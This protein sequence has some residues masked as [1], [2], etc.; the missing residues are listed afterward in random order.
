MN[1]KDWKNILILMPI[2]LFAFFSNIWVRPADLMEAR[3][4]IT[5]REMIQNANYVI[6]TLNG[7]LRFEKPPLPTWLTAFV[8]KVTGNI[9]DEWL[10]RIPVAL[11]A[12]L[13]IILLYYFIKIMTESSLKSFITAFIGTTTFM[14]IK[15][16]NEN[17][18]DMYPYVFAFGAVT[19]ILKGLKTSKTKYFIFS[20][21]FI[22]FS[23]LS[24]GPV[25]IYGLIIPFIISHIYVYG[26]ENYKKNWK[27]F[28]FMIIIAVILAGIWPALV[29]LKYPETFLSVL[30]K[31]EGTWMNN[32]TESFI[33]YMDYFVYM[34]IWIFFSVMTLIKSWNKNRTDDKNFSKFILLWNI[35]IIILLSVIKMKKKRYGLP[36]YMTSIIGVGVICHYYYDKLWFELKK[37]DRI[38]LYIQGGFMGIISFLIPILLF[39]KGYLSGT[40]KGWY[41]IMLIIIFIP[42]SYIT[43]KSL[44]DK[45]LWS[46]KFI[47]F[48]SGILMLLANA[49][50]NWFFDRTIIKNSLS[51]T[52][53]EYQ[54]MKIVHKNPPALDIYSNNYE[55]EDVWRVGKTIKDYNKN[56]NDNLPNN[57]IFFG[58]VPENLMENYSLLKKE[59]YIKDDGHMAELNY[60]EKFK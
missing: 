18:W 16:G 60:L 13:F 14:I 35:L 22:A 20:G 3:N 9:T 36:I 38:L 58:E 27:N 23:I 8:M 42:F 31:E 5:A 33:Y 12:I 43:I 15:I 57:L 54:Q 53:P 26:T 56:E 7:K 10:L 40:V 51:N 59:I 25:G 47:I 55:I 32:H 49:T 24:K 19:F 34:G 1:T 45:K 39:A 41:I 30:K 6:T 29:Y 21:I 17:A 52:E 50:T 37:S 4:F 28:I 11:V 48:G 46:I 44:I 2:S